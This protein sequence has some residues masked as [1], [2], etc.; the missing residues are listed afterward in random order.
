MEWEKLPNGKWKPKKVF[1][2]NADGKY[3]PDD[4]RY[5]KI[6]D[7]KMKKVVLFCDSCKDFYNLFKPCVHHLPDT[8]ENNKIRKE[9]RKNNS[10]N[11]EF[12]NDNTEILEF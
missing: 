3:A 5:I 6:R 7:E 2:K 12:K 11:N 4:P 10:N 8:Y 1:R 9:Y